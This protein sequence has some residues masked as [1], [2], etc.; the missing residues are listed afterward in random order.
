[1]LVYL[2]Q[3]FVSSLVTLLI[4]SI[5]C[6][7]IIN[8]PAGDVMD[9]YEWHL[10]SIGYEADSARE[11]ANGLRRLYGLD[12]SMP[13]QYM[14]WL[15][16]FV[17]GDFGYS[18]RLLLLMLNITSGPKVDPYPASNSRVRVS[19]ISSSSSSYENMILYFP[20]PNEPWTSELS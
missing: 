16:R 12:Q 4:I 8:L 1:M 9:E 6:F 20:K 14:I 11:T 7:V 17:Q 15:T 5:V 18:M 13:V 10:R 2:L 3:R 19:I